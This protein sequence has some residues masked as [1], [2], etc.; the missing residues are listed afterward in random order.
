MSRS[1]LLEIG[2]ESLPGR[3]LSPALEQME[4]LAAELLKQE[5]LAF[6]SAKAYGTP[7]RLALVVS[8]LAERSS[9]LEVEASGP[10]ARLLKDEQ[11]RFTPQAEGFA[12]VQGVRPQDLQVKSTPKG[13]FLCARKTLPGEAAPKVL[14]RVFPEL[15][16]RLQFPKTM[17]WEESRLRFARPIRTLTALCGKKA[18]PLALAGVRSA[19]RV[20]GLACLGYK[21]IPVADAERYLRLLRDRCVLADPAERREAL[22]KSIDQA[23]KRASGKVD[24]DAEL[25]EQIVALTEHP[26]ALLGRF[27]PAFLELPEPLLLTVL[28]G[29][30]KVFPLLTGTGLAAEFIAVRD[31]VSE[32]Q[33][34]VQEG[35][36]RVLSAR[37]SDARFFFRKDRESD[38]LSKHARLDG[39]GFQRGLGSMKSKAERVVALSGWILERLLQDRDVDGEAVA[40]IARRAYADLTTGVV[41]EFPELQGT[42][43]GV[44]ARLDGL[45]ERVALGVEEF[46]FPSAAKGP[47]P[48]TVEGRIVSL[49]GKIDTIAAMFAGGHKPSGS[50]DPF[51]LRRAGNGFVRI[52]L[53]GQIPLSASE[54]AREALRLVEESL[55]RASVKTEARFDEPV[56]REILEF[57]W[58][59]AESLFLELGYKVDELRAVAAGGLDDLPRTLRRLA[60]VHALRPDPDFVPLAQAFKRASNILK[61]AGADGQDEVQAE[62]LS[63]EA[64]RGLFEALCRVEGEVRERLASGCYEEGLRSLVGLKPDVDRFFDKVLVMAEDASLKRNRL[65]LLARLVRLFRQVADIAHIQN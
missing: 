48:T 37:L 51:G 4:R 49:A 34:E 31:G 18:L 39:I 61:Q 19:A 30:L 60:A 56:E 27:D 17:E 3:F 58:Q 13:D 12:R 52:L 40:E 38:L 9:A 2:T 23:A 42:M 62:L 6:E 20:R 29:Q 53:E 57:L 44:Y 50:E 1:A 25:V 7:M 64:E 8:G 63:E 5:R 35:F 22:L 45:D 41:S 10:P 33:K 21:P 65:S 55:A 46:H 36:E 47:L 59:R 43:G 14:A 15:I 11:G 24:K 16:K 32:G 54:L 28:K 26:V